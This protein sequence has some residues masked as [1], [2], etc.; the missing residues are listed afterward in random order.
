M[1][2]HIY[3]QCLTSY[4]MLSGHILYSYYHHIHKSITQLDDSE[5][6]SNRSFHHSLFPRI[7]LLL[8]RPDPAL[9]F[10]STSRCRNSRRHGCVFKRGTG[11]GTRLCEATRWLPC[12]SRIC[13]ASSWLLSDR[14]PHHGP[15]L[16][17]SILLI[18][19]VSS[20]FL[21]SSL[22]SDYTHAPPL[23]FPPNLSSTFFTPYYT[24]SY[25]V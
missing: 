16:E 17:V 19:V 20:S 23:L 9:Y 24:L 11:T 8:L 5:V 12:L 4:D 1:Q 3:F 6:I 7:A 2:D 13:S 14:A 10:A 25:L 15:L 18:I 22:S 21:S